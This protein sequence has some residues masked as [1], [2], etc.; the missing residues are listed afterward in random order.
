MQYIL[1]SYAFIYVYFQDI[2]SKV[3]YVISGIRSIAFDYNTESDKVFLENQHIKWPPIVWD[4][5]GTNNNNNMEMQE[6]RI[7]IALIEPTNRYYEY[8]I[9]VQVSEHRAWNKYRCNRGH[10]VCGLIYFPEAIDSKI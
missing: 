8:F 7:W 2:I 9:D 10:T 5:I 3:I 4:V 1:K 6:T